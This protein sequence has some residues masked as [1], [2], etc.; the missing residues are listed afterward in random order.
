MV[1]PALEPEPV[2][3]EEHN[4]CD[5]WTEGLGAAKASKIASE[6]MKGR[7][8]S[9]LQIEVPIMG[10]VGDP[11]VLLA[12]RNNDRRLPDARIAS[13]ADVDWGCCQREVDLWV[14]VEQRMRCPVIVVGCL[15]VNE[16]SIA[17]GSLS[18]SDKRL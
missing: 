6:L 14:V 12:L 3:C 9:R 15:V 11:E 8:L 10:F 4:S 7:A 17:K 16:S 13:G 18:T 5:N 1:I 2:F